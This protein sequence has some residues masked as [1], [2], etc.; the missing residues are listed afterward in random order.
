[1]NQILVTEKLYVTP[2]LKRKRKIYKILFLISVIITVVLMSF[3]FY[4][5]YDKA[6]LES[7]S[8][9]ILLD[10]TEQAE[11]LEEIAE[12][13]NV[14]KIIISTRDELKKENDIKNANESSY[15]L[16]N[17]PI[18]EMKTQNATKA[19]TMTN[20][21]SQ[22]STY[23]AS[24][25]KNYDTVGRIK[26]P[27]INCEYP[28]LAE[29]SETLLKVAPC[30]FWGPETNTIGNLCIAGH[31]WK[32]SKFFS[33]VPTLIEG[34]IIEITD[35]SGNTLKYSVYD[36][37]TVD[38]KDTSCTSQNTNG[39]KIVTLITCT[40]DNQKRVIVHAKEIV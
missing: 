40:N 26:I 9:D 2:E 24:N 37:Y 15:I 1:M 19:I 10:L 38:P 4:A 18:L 27:K 14:W 34:D 8:Q 22:H 35:V 13:E 32:N 29:T 33:K 31:N 16:K 23:T 20:A 21:T 3:Y 25:G 11:T 17:E 12:E 7:I 36:K 6:R 39:K 30:K 5:E 28:I